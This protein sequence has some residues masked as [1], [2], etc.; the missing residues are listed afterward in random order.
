MLPDTSEACRA[1]GAALFLTQSA[2][3]RAPD[4]PDPFQG[5]VTRKNAPGFGS[6]LLKDVSLFLFFHF[7]LRVYM[8]FMSL[9]RLRQGS[10]V[11]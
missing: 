6:Q 4:G 3:G 8:L 9:R 2:R 1:P 11:L 5:D 7:S 10:E